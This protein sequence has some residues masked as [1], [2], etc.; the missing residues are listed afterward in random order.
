MKFV[1]YLAKIS[2][3]YKDYPNKWV[4]SYPK[5]KKT[6]PEAKKAVES[7][8]K[9]GTTCVV[10]CK[11]ALKLMGL[12]PDGFYGY[13]GTFR[14]FDADLKKVMRKIS[15]GDVIGLTVK[16][17]VD[18]GLLRTGDIIAFK[19]G[20]HT[21]V[22]SG[23]GYKVYDGGHAALRAKYK[24]GILMDYSKVLSQRGRKISCICR[25]K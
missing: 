8:K 14:G 15:S 17:A 24:T 12:N 11:W 22:Y 1:G 9:T 2:Q 4:Y 6:Y 25:W 20:T 16:K 7:G 13:K 23:K 19:G 3:T 18:R 21:F 5:A 10:P